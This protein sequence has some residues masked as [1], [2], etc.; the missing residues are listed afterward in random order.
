MITIFTFGSGF[1]YQGFLALAVEL[2][3][4]FDRLVLR[5][6]GLT[7][8]MCQTG[9]ALGYFVAV[10]KYM[11]EIFSFMYHRNGENLFAN[12]LGYVCSYTTDRLI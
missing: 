11:Y 4:C 3:T 10:M 5:F 8:A 7:G 12:T 6:G 2:S 9:W 1:C